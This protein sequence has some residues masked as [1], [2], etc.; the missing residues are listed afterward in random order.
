MTTAGP[1]MQKAEVSR[2]VEEVIGFL[3]AIAVVSW[4]RP[5]LG[6]CVTLTVG[7][8]GNVVLIMMTVMT[9]VTIGYVCLTDTSN[10][11][12]RAGASITNEWRSDWKIYCQSAAKRCYLMN[13]LQPA[14]FPHHYAHNSKKHFIAANYIAILLC[15]I[16]PPN[17][18]YTSCFPCREASQPPFCS[19]VTVSVCYYGNS[20]VCLTC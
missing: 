13:L 17:L 8:R 11:W 7:Q 20:G 14:A 9:P 19:G 4:D 15:L 16:L 3:M 5:W 10:M 6:P 12:I 18:Q 2:H 1:H